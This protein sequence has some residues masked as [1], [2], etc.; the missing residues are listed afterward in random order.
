VIDVHS[1]TVAPC[2]RL[3]KLLLSVTRTCWNT[4]FFLLSVL[5]HCSCPL[6][7]DRKWWHWLRRGM[8][9]TPSP[10]GQYLRLLCWGVQSKLLRCA[11]PVATSRF[12]CAAAGKGGETAV[13]Q[14]HV[15]HAAS[16]K[17]PAAEHAVT[18]L[19]TISGADARLV[20]DAPF[21]YHWPSGE[22]ASSATVHCTL[23]C[24]RWVAAPC[25]S[26]YD[27]RC[28]LLQ[29]LSGSHWRAT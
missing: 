13:E 19:D 23:D 14:A 5:S 28:V 12:A 4:L 2:L 21:Y 1:F 26:Q 16:C 8:K 22:A 15:Q 29:Q 25:C 27:Q 6:R 24:V 18:P 11:K 3:S 7:D 20:L 9:K 17:H 10:P